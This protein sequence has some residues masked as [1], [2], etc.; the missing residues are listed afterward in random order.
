MTKFLTNDL[1]KLFQRLCG[2]TEFKSFQDVKSFLLQ[3]KKH[4]VFPPLL[5]ATGTFGEVMA[6]L[7]PVLLE[8]AQK[9]QGLVDQKKASTPSKIVG[10][11]EG[12]FVVPD[13]PFSLDADSHVFSPVK[14]KIRDGEQRL[15]EYREWFTDPEALALYDC[16]EKIQSA[17]IRYRYE[18]PVEKSPEVDDRLNHELLIAAEHVLSKKQSISDIPQKERRKVALEFIPEVVTELLSEYKKNGTSIPWDDAQINKQASVVIMKLVFSKTE[19][20]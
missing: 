18:A 10:E 17:S 19:A 16:F 1:H 15:R 9:V 20:K 2:E 7:T 5:L 4:A 14:V 12:V 6:N 8:E 11:F 13:V 3:Q